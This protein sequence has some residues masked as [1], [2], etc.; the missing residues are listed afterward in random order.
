MPQE[1]EQ[2]DNAII[3]ILMAILASVLR[4]S[5]SRRS[6]AV[7]QIAAH[8]PNQRESRGD[9]AGRHP[10]EQALVSQSSAEENPRRKPLLHA[11]C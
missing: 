2:E 4:I 3:L 1:N 10:V 5:D 8:S 9:L 7:A 11:L 6:I